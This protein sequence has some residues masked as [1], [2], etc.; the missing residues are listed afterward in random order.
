MEPETFGR[1]VG[2][3]RGRCHALRRLDLGHEAL[4]LPGEAVEAQ[5]GQAL[6]GPGVDVAPWPGIADGAQGEAA[7][8]L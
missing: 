2:R 7:G 3:V 4:V 6:G 8:L 5:V 1:D